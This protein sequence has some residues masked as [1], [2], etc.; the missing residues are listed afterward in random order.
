MQNRPNTPL[1]TVITASWNSAKTIRA[2]LR[3]VQA[4]DYGAIEHLVVDGGSTDG[5]LDILHDEAAEN[6]VWKSERDKGIYD[7][8]NKGLVRARGT[9]IAFLG[10]DDLFLPGAISA[11]MHLAAQHPSAQYMSGQVRWIGPKGPRTIGE[12]WSWPRFQRY[13]CVAHVGSMHHRSLFEQYGTYDTSLR[14]VADYELLLRARGDLRTAFLPQL[15]TEML[16]GGASDS[17]AALRETRRVKQNTGGRPPAKAAIDHA[18]AQALF[19]K[20]RWIA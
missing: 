9:W 10:S 8:W 6:L 11:Y 18:M 7:A 17:I 12:P 2:C 3:S 1:V 15:T 20:Q 13:M 19:Y 5:T 4:Q 14:I 16:C